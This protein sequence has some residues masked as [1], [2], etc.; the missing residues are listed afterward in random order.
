MIRSIIAQNDNVI[1]INATIE[2][3]LT[4]ACNSEHM[5][6]TPVQRLR[7]P[8]RFRARGLCVERRQI[9]HRGTIDRSRR[10]GV[11]H[12]PQGSKGR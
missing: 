11:A 4:G 6:G 7:R 12:L 5:L 3:D 9:D 8:T 10:Q 2:I 1:S